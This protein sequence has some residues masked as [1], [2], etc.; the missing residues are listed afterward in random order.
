MSQRVTRRP[1]TI[2][3]S[4]SRASK[5]T[6]SGDT[7]HIL[8]RTQLQLS[9]ALTRESNRQ[10]ST[11]KLRR[12]LEAER[13][14]VGALELE[15][16]LISDSLDLALQAQN[17]EQIGSNTSEQKALTLRRQIKTDR[18]H[19]QRVLKAKSSIT[20][21]CQDL[22]DKNKKL[23]EELSLAHS[24]LLLSKAPAQ[25]VPT[26]PDP[27]TAKN[28]EIDNLKV[29]LS[30]AVIEAGCMRSQLASSHLENSLLASSNISNSTKLLE[31]EHVAKSLRTELFE[32]KNK[33]NKRSKKLKS[34][35]MALLRRT[36]AKASLSVKLHKATSFEIRKKGIVTG[37]A[38]SIL[39]DMTAAGC[40]MANA[41]QLLN[42]VVE[43]VAPNC[44]AAKAAKPI[45]ARTVGRAIGEGSV[46][47]RLQIVY[48]MKNANGASALL[49]FL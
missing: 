1:R 25:T 5:A 22:R 4:D 26:L 17:N 24:E 36:R 47:A 27:L 8:R 45:S 42:Q 12:K 46:A 32:E 13:S 48:E 18:Q 15:L 6:N 14:R 41:G 35:Q 19:L 20:S 10:M 16:S 29:A 28:I 38:R 9:R 3:D 2:A 37:K 33:S 30:A 34:N 40:S 44:N 23:H 43:A 49:L 7:N 39:R 31:A 11:R 21:E